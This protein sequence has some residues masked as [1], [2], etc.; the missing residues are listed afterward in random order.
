[1]STQWITKL[2]SMSDLIGSAPWLRTVAT[3]AVLAAGSAAVQAGAYPAWT[4][5]T[6]GDRVGAYVQPAGT[7]EEF[8]KPKRAMAVRIEPTV[9]D[10]GEWS[11]EKD[12]PIQPDG[13]LQVGAKL[14]EAG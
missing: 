7:V 2:R 9:V 3:T 6:A 5:D 14:L 11:G 10:L 13:V 12:L 1:M 4:P 8:V